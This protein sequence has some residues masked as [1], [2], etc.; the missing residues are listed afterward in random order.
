MV[1][2]R[3]FLVAAAVVGIAGPAYG[4]SDDGSARAGRG[5]GTLL[6]RVL[7]AAAVAASASP[8]KAKIGAFLGFDLEREVL[9]EIVDTLQDEL[10][11][12][13]G[14]TIQARVV[15]SREAAWR[16]CDLQ[17]G[18]FV[19]AGAPAGGQALEVVIEGLPSVSDED[20]ALRP[21]LRRLLAPFHEYVAANI[22]AQL[23]E[24]GG[25]A[26]FG[27]EGGEPRGRRAEQ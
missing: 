20:A 15:E 21:F 8:L 18:R 3:G 4:G 10:R 2:R 9:N 25:E 12:R 7:N 6:V 22:M 27:F 24:Y 26:V 11:A 13:V 17:A 5:A 1:D 19:P 23:A 14:L 16:Q